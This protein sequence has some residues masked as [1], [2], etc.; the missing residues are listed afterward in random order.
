[1]PP[2]TPGTKRRLEPQPTVVA[3]RERAY[4]PPHARA[5]RLPTSLL[6]ALSP[7]G[8]FLLFSFAAAPHN[9]RVLSQFRGTKPFA[10]SPTLRRL[11]G[12]PPVALKYRTSHAHSVPPP[13][14]CGACRPSTDILRSDEGRRFFQ[15]RPPG[16]GADFGQRFDRGIKVCLR[17]RGTSSRVPSRYRLEA[18]ND[19]GSLP[20]VLY[21]HALFTLFGPDLQAV[22]TRGRPKACWATLPRKWTVY[23]DMSTCRFSTSLRG[24]S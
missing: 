3:R 11:P 22:A 10:R 8:L 4:P 12:A 2:R 18:H 15:A 23:T 20:V 9:A 7:A 24:M 14:V 13:A 17:R 21:P 5:L 16:R 19:A 6:T 1:M